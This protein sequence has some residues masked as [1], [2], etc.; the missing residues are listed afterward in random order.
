MESSDVGCFLSNNQTQT[1]QL[2]LFYIDEGTE[3]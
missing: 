1:H 2:G 3:E